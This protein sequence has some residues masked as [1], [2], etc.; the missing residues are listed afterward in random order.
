[1][2][3]CSALLGIGVRSVTH[4]GGMTRKSIRLHLE[5]GGSVIATRRRKPDRAEMEAHV[6]RALSERGVA[7][8]RVLGFDGTI[9]LQEDVAGDRLAVVLSEA[10]P[11]DGERWLDAALHGLAQAQRAGREARLQLRVP[12][13]GADADWIATLVE[14]PARICDYL[15]LPSPRLPG[16]ELIERLKVAD[17]HFIK[18][19]ARPGNALARA[20]GRVAWFDWEHCGARDR[21]CDM[22][23][24]LGDEYVPDWPAVEERLISKHLAEFA[25]GE[26]RADAGDYLA[27]FGTFHILVRLGLILLRKKDGPWWDAARCL[28]GDKVGVTQEQALRIAR[29]AARWAGRS[30][31]TENLSPALARVADRIA[32]LG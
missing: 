5:D 23:W 24:L 27:A 10:A 13:I 28:A 25:D 26:D 8:P 18:W 6:L 22:A 12:R 19:D 7:V 2:R 1:M 11:E 16:P 9:L 20:D 30:R 29:R 17:P 31:L 32:E 3:A 14:R 21:L 4:P 15:G